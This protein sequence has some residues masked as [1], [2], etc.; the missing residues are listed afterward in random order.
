MQKPARKSQNS[1]DRVLRFH[2]DH[3]DTDADKY[4]ADVLDAVIGQQPLE[5]MLAKGVD[6]T[7]DAGHH[8]EDQNHRSQN[9]RM[10]VQDAV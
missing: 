2:A 8:T 6:D 7:Q 5:V 9:R 4:D 1:H 3:A 10:Q